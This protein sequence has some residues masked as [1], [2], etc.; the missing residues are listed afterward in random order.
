M[1]CASEIVFY[2][3][4]TDLEALASALK[5]YRDGHSD[6][7]NWIEDTTQRQENTPRQTDS[8]GLSEQLAQQTVSISG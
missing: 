3:R 8:R 4:R 5:H 6:L 1:L 7:I 2:C